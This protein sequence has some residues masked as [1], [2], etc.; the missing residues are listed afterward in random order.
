MYCQRQNKA[1]RADECILPEE[2]DPDL[3]Y[4]LQALKVSRERTYGLIAPLTAAGE[5]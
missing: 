3:T 5:M 2:K 4:F 1:L